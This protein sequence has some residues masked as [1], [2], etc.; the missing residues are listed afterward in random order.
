MSEDGV[1]FSELKLGGTPLLEDWLA[2]DLKDSRLYA[3]VSP[4]EK[5]FLAVA[6]KFISC[7]SDGDIW[8]CPKLRVEQIFQVTAYFD[9]VRH[10]E[11]NRGSEDQAG[12]LYYPDMEGL[13]LMLSAVRNLEETF[14][15]DCEKR[16]G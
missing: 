7:V 1:L 16:E 14:C 13:I 6:V 8:E 15:P 2:I 5:S 9:G 10:L 11:F 12:Y 3:R 4:G